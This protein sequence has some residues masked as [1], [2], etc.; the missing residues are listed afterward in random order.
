[1]SY[2][3]NSLLNLRGTRLILNTIKTSVDTV[4]LKLS[5]I[6]SG[7][8]VNTVTS[9]NNQVG[10][11]IITCSTLGAEDILNKVT[12]V[13]S[14]STDTQY[15]SAKCVY[16]IIGDVSSLLTTLTGT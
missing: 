7:A 14:S 12:S 8:Q 1:M 10:D 9:V 3:E 6:E 4:V 13:S 2:S 11:V 16:D 15:P 5:T